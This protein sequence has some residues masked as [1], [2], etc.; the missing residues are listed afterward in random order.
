[1]R[2]SSNE[3]FS[4]LNKPCLVVPCPVQAGHRASSLRITLSWRPDGRT[5]LTHILPTILGAPMAARTWLTNFQHT[6]QMRFAHG[7]SSEERCFFS[8][9]CKVMFCTTGRVN[10]RYEGR[11]R[12]AQLCNCQRHDIEPRTAW[13]PSGWKI[14][15]PYRLTILPTQTPCVFTRFG[16][17]AYSKK[18]TSF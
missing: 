18:P 8:F 14:V 15:S 5:D 9:W 16:T 2:V 4:T 17:L 3:L 13:L 1:M 7:M 6:T 12:S 11:K 10:S